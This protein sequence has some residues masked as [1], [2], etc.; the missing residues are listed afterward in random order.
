VGGRVLFGKWNFEL[1]TRSFSSTTFL[2]LL[3]QGARKRKKSS[4]LK[5]HKFVFFRHISLGQK[6]SS[7]KW[8]ANGI[9]Y[10]KKRE[11]VLLFGKY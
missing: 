9:G 4:A 2:L 6:K 7:V 3:F 8:Q 11:R 5:G 10:T 1:K